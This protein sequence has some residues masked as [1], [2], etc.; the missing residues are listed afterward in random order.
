[1]CSSNSTVVRVAVVAAIVLR[2]L[3]ALKVQV[4]VK[5]QAYTVNGTHWLE[6][7]TASRNALLVSTRCGDFH[8]TVNKRMVG[9]ELQESAKLTTA[10]ALT[11]GP[12]NVITQTMGRNE[13]FP[14]S[15]FIITMVP[16]RIMYKQ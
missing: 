15:F 6:S 4:L 10:R 16:M 9:G 8:F 12:P 7:P 5:E 1:M 3:S 2:F 14:K 11:T 13:S